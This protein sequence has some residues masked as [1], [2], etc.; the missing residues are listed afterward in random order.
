MMSFA[1]HGIEIP[2]TASGPEVQTTCPRCSDQRRKN[3]AKCL[4]VNVEKGAWICHHCGWA[5]GLGKDSNRPGEPTH[6]RRAQYRR[7][8]PRP[9]LTI[10]QHGVDWFH[11]RGIT[12]AV[13]SR[14]RIDY[15]RVYMPQIEDHAEALIFP[16]FRNGELLNRK[17][18]TLAEKHFRL[19]PGCELLLYGVDDIDPEKPLIWVEGE[20]DK[21]AVEV[22][23]IRNCVSVPNGAPPPNAKNYDALLSFLEADREKI[24]AVKQHI[25]AVDA[26]APGRRLEE[27]LSRRLGQEKCSRVRWPE[28]RKDA[29]EV[30][31]R[32][33]AEDLRWFI[34]NAERFP[35]EGVFEIADCLQDLHRLYNHGFDP[36]YRTGWRELDRLYTVRP[37]EF[38]AV[39][40]IPSSGKSNWLDCLL[41]NLAKLHG[42]SFALFSPENLPL[43]QHMASIAEKFIGK[44]FHD[45]PTQRMTEREFESTIQWINN[46][47]AWIMPGNEED[48][49]V[50]KI[51]S[52]ASQLCLR[53]GIRGLVIDP[54]NELEALRPAGLSETEYISQSL[55]RIRV[56][57]RQRKIHV[58]IVIH[59]AKLYRDDSGRYPVPTLYDCAGSAHWRNKAD[60]GLVVWRDLSGADSAEVQ[61]HV[62]KIRFRHVGR[63]GMARLF[64]DPVCATYNEYEQRESPGYYA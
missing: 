16:Y 64:Y 14:S 3:K 36:S 32:D 19:E 2:Q 59:P 47:F 8:D 33:G 13:R 60:N 20:C 6:W 28:G 43:E 54:W 9:Q 30:L 23:G 4:S 61:I 44:P 24:E 10:P 39:T 1:D 52:T 56:F 55:K 29:N 49:T 41:V 11:S 25:I 62:Q 26:D 22:A 42:W 63:R 45:G 15:G 27:E 18:R 48:W 5:A 51:L 40:G 17:Y 37:G 53:R 21:L 46:H 50:D 7:P 12:D 57:A 34:E 35:L 58:W 31:V 38:T